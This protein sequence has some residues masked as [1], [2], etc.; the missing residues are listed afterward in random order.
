M[1]VQPLPV[2][3]PPK[4]T[5]IHLHPPPPPTHTP[6]G[7]GVLYQLEGEAK[8]R[9][10]WALLC[11]A[12]IWAPCHR[13]WQICPVGRGRDAPALKDT[14]RLPVGK[15]GVLWTSEYIGQCRSKYRLLK[16]LVYIQYKTVYLSIN[17]LIKVEN[18]Y[19]L[20][21]ISVIFC[22]KMCN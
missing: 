22:L 11:R 9:E 19:S 1:F 13:A 3:G 15:G 12:V 7:H 8:S 14:P 20:M 6:I 21:L 5:Q 17:A 10:Q 4:H 16:M 2:V 18:G